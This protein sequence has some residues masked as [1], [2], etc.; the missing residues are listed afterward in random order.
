LGNVEDRYVDSSTEINIILPP[1]GGQAL[2]FTP[3]G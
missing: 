2:W 3:E 1:G